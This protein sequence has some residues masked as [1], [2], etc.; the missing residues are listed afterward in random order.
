MGLMLTIIVLCVVLGVPG[1][2]LWWKVADKWA[3]AEHKRFP[4]KSD[5]SKPAAGPA[6]TVVDLDT[7][8]KP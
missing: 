3:D 7:D 1:T 2:L 5:S 8:T 4:L 6:P